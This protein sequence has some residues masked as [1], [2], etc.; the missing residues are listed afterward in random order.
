MTP[1]APADRLCDHRRNRVGPLRE[2]QRLQLLGGAAGHKLRLSL[3]LVATAVVVRRAGAQH[4]Q[5]LKGQLEVR[6]IGGNRGE[7][8]RG[9]GD[10]MV[11]LLPGNHLECDWAGPMPRRGS[12]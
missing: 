3:A 5:R 7:R 2:N 11:P 1:P 12:G 4:T 8:C 10:P 6:V 9:E